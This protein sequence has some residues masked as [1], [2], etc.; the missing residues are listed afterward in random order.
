MRLEI[1]NPY[2]TARVSF[3]GAE[4]TASFDQNRISVTLPRMEVYAAVVI[5]KDE[6]V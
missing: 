1:E 3:R 4:G 5:E 6:K 2:S